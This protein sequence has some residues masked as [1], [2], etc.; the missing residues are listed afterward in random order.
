MTIA[1]KLTKIAENVPKVYEQGKQAEHDAFWE[2]YQRGGAT[3]ADYSNAFYT[4]RWTDDIY[5]PKY[6]IVSSNSFNSLFAY[7]KITDTLVT[8]DA[9]LLT[10]SSKQQAL[11]NYATQLKT[12]PLIRV[13]EHNTYSGWF[14]NC[15]SL[16]NI[17]FEGV[18][19]NDID[20][21]YSTK[22]TRVSI[23]SIISH[24]C[25]TGDYYGTVTL[26]LEAVDREFAEYD[27]DGEIFCVGSETAD[28]S[29]CISAA[30]M[31]WDIALV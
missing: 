21:R 20:F 16:E 19:G 7:S 4:G 1:E 13:A 31:Y 18:I 12:I 10:S 14:S 11:F 17:S 9:T 30:S 8:I 28:W 26:S 24:L 29:S 3:T 6:D 23:E 27:T 25:V 5:K 22:L 15:T 2:Q